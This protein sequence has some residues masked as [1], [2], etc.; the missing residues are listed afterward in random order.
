MRRGG[1][2]K[3]SD[4]LKE[5]LSSSKCLCPAPG[6]REEATVSPYLLSDGKG[7]YFREL[8][9][10]C[11]SLL[12]SL[13]SLDGGTGLAGSKLGQLRVLISPCLPTYF[14]ETA[15]GCTSLSFLTKIPSKPWKMHSGWPGR[16][17]RQRAS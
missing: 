10:A 6:H 4:R 17:G 15:S 13:R 9:V 7:N 5:Q 12:L 16:D 11:L 14:L 3:Y 1:A 2:S 8:S